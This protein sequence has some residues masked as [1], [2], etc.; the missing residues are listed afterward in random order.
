[1][2]LLTVANEFTHRWPLVVSL[3]HS[4]TWCP[5]SMRAALRPD[6]VL[7]NTDWFLPAL[8]EW[9][10]AMGVT[11]LVNRVNRYVADPNRSRRGPHDGSYEQTAVYTRNTFGH[12]LYRTPLPP[13]VIQARLRAYHTPYRDR[14][15]ALLAAKQATFGRV[16]LL[17]LHS[18]AEYPHDHETPPADVVIGNRHDLT[19]SRA[20]RQRISA[21][22][23]DEGFSVAANHPFAGGDITQTYGRLPGVAALQ[24]ELRYRCYIATR[25]FG[26]VQL[27]AP[28]PVLFATATA[29]LK[30]ALQPLITALS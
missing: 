27:T 18:F 17:D 29:R 5:A 2:P 13:R 3:P 8:Y 1:M 11:T 4:G 24:V 12:P 25:A 30:R 26:E 10:P 19:A 7:A 16:V 21:A 15:Q 14:L 6:V 23:A 20:I 22:L 9:L 28:D